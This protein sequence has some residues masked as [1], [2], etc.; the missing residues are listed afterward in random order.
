MNQFFRNH[1][2]TN[3]TE[4]VCERKSISGPPG[5]VEK[6][7]FKSN[8][9]NEKVP[10]KQIPV[11]APDCNQTILLHKQFHQIND[12]SKLKIL[13]KMRNQRWDKF[14]ITHVLILI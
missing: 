1:A 10:R 13:L 14:T 4:I 3:N 12:F 9:K 8:V 6:I 2:G 5:N 11:C 7:S